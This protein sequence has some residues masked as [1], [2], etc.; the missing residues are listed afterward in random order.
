MEQLIV[1]LAVNARDAMPQGGTLRITTA[2]MELDADFVRRHEGAVAGR[3]VALTVQDSGCGM[4]ADVLAHVFEPFFT[5]KPAGKGTGLGLSTVYGIVKQS[6][7]Y[8]AIDSQPGM[9]TTVATYLPVAADSQPIH[10][11]APDSSKSLSG[12]ETVLLVEDEPGLRRLMQRTL[13]QYGYTVLNTN[14]VADAIACAERHK[15]RIDLLLSDVVMPG[16]SGPDLAQ[17]I[18]RLR[19]TIKVLYVSGFTSHAALEA[20]SLSARACFLGKPFTP[21]VLAATVRQCLDSDAV[22]RQS[23]HA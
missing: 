16:L 23:Q 7:G 6:G 14:T 2:N 5:T 13:Q 4:T 12:T 3:Y 9:G 20:G 15:G 22:E 21:H 1:N 19:P 17:R 8:I 11:S 18:V 10:V